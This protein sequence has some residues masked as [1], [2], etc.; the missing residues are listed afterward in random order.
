[1]VRK[2][3]EERPVTLE[4]QTM[5]P[6]P[7]AQARSKLR[8]LRT[9]RRGESSALRVESSP[10][11][12][13]LLAAMHASE[14]ETTRRIAELREQIIARLDAMIEDLPRPRRRQSH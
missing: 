2:T 6:E 1:M 13:A 12:L 4:Q 11:V 14:N 3:L 5:T 9:A 10:E 8:K 7:P